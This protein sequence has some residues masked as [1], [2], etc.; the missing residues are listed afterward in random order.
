MKKTI[1]LLVGL[2]LLLTAA[3]TAAPTKPT[4]GSFTNAGE[5]PAGSKLIVDI[6]YKVANDEDSGNVGYWALDSY[7]K[8][9]QV[10]QAPDGLNYVVARYTGKSQTFAGALSPGVGATEGKDATVNFEGGYIASFTGTLDATKQTHG[11]IGTFD[12]G[13]T[14]A[15]VLLGSYGAGQTG[16]SSPYSFLSDYFPG[17]SGFSQPNWGWTYHYRSQSWNNFY[18]G[19]TGDVVA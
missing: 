9:V 11:N 12:F 3:V 13:G 2:M 19:T 18:Y 17:Y 1:L 15:D 14:K 16:P 7:N 4:W 5:V 10:W 6:T 8:H